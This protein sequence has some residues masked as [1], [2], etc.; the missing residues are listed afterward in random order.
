MVCVTCGGLAV[1]FFF[2]VFR[3]SVATIEEYTP[4]YLKQ[5]GLSAMLIGFVPTFGILT[6]ALGVPLISYLSDKF[7]SRKL[8]LMFSIIIVIPHILAF[9]LV[10][11]NN[12]DCESHNG[13]SN[14]ASENTEVNKHSMPTN[15]SE[16]S[17]RSTSAVLMT[18]KAFTGGSSS[19]QLYFVLAMV[20][21][22][23]GYELVKRFIVTQITVA[24][25]THTKK[26]KT[27]YGYYAFWGQIGAGISLFAIGILVG[28]FRV[29]I[30]NKMEPGYFLAFYYAAGFQLT[31]L[32]PLNWL[33]FEYLEKRVIDYDEVKSVIF[34]P[35]YL[36]MLGICLYSGM[37][38]AFQFRWEY[39]YIEELG[40]GPVL[41]AVGGFVRRPLVGLWYLLSRTAI[42]RLGE[43]NAMC[44][45]IFLFSGSFIALAFIK[46]PWLV[47]VCDIFQSL[48]FVLL[49]SSMVVHFSKAGSKA[50]SAFIQ[51]N[52]R[53]VL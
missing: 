17:Q 12:T 43:Y 10:Q 42:S 38:S 49:M 44:L 30:C 14:L 9:I 16:T 34:N 40:G 15:A 31:T 23:G 26:D 28:Y 3:S 52:K 32:I 25:I 27:K 35:H 29:S 47:I 1:S 13:T 51:G 45:A 46:A 22:R 6:Q 7:R 2:F 20:A 18:T 48:A 50:S 19:E 37:C 11:Y 21:L 53:F 24:T 5:K 33:K 8:F 36:L 39:W 4:L 41:F